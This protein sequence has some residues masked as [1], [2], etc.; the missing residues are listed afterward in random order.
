MAETTGKRFR[1]P[2]QTTSPPDV[3]GWLKTGLQD[4]DDSVLWGPVASV[5]ATLKVGQ[6]YLGH[7]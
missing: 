3:A 1:L 2:D 7:A 5:P 4:V 6:V